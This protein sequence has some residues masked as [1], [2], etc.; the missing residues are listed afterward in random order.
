[1]K[2]QRMRDEMTVL[3]ALIQIQKPS[4][5]NVSEATGISQEKVQKTLHNI[6]ELFGVKFQHDR[7]N[8]IEKIIIIEWGVFES[9]EK[10]RKK[11][12]KSQLKKSTPPKSI[13]FKSKKNKYD[14]AKLKNYRASLKLEGIKSSEREI[15]SDKKERQHLRQSLLKKH[16]QLA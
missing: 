8:D 7:T 2:V 16:T 14:I 10:L 9:G 1:M 11:L 13:S 6:T 12:S 5:Q 4:S 3:A 15:P